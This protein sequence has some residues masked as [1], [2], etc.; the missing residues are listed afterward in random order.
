MFATSCRILAVAV[1]MA[2]AAHATATAAPPPGWTTWL[3]PDQS[4][5]ELG[6]PA[7]AGASRLAR[8]ALRQNA[9]RLGLPPALAGVR[10]AHRL[11]LPARDGAGALRQLRF[12][13]TAGALR[14]VWSQIDVDV[15][16]GRVSSIS[17]TVVPVGPGAATGERRIGRARALRIAHRALPGRERALQ[18]L[19]AAYAG[20]PATNRSAR[21]RR[22]RRAWVVELHRA[23][24]PTSVCIVVDAASG[25]VIARWPGMADR[26]GA[27]ATARASQAR[28]PR[29]LKVNDA[30][31]TLDNPP[32]Y[33]QFET[34]GRDPRTSRW[35][36][37]FD[38]ILPGVSRSRAMDA[39]TANTANVARTICT[40]RGYCGSTGG[41]GQPAAYRNWRVLANTS[42]NDSRAECGR[43]NVFLSARDI[44]FG[45]G[46]PNQPANDMVAHEMG[47]IMDC[48]YAGDRSATPGAQGD[49]AEEALAD[50]FAFDYDR[51]DARIGEDSVLRRD[52]GV[53]GSLALGG[54]RFPDHMSDFDPTP[55]GGAPHF[56]STI[57][58]HGYFL[59]VQR[60][61]HAR[62]GRVLHSV[63]SFLSPRPTFAEVAR[64]FHT[65]ASQIYGTGAR[66]SARAAFTAVGLA[67]G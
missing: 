7:D 20:T 44:M 49:S 41:F 24:A 16:A 39:A 5:R 42:E 28:G 15:V 45:N 12:Q 33:A 9:R 43:L 53:P 29:L 18:P 30:T 37:W 65:R 27:S 21:P 38:A 55:P 22:G 32:L 58:S 13:Q 36:A 60:E 4:A 34:E 64:A 14:V 2:G 31:R 63:P 48:V 57:L 23:T 8:A 54:Q 25:R 19:P 3:Q 17:A 66:N 40:V 46:D 56:N 67:P 11:R 52:I 62:A 35:P 50:M 1:L 6:L 59:F 10:L 61:G 51:F 47:H 26:P